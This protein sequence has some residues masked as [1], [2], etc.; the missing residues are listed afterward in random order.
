MLSLSLFVTSSFSLAHLSEGG[1]GVGCRVGQVL[2][3]GSCHNAA[4]A[5]KHHG[6]TVHESSL[7][8]PHHT[9]LC[10]KRPKE[11]RI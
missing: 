5:G 4:A 8:W 7:I 3:G 2:G 11:Q 9:V 10:V 6:C 1:L